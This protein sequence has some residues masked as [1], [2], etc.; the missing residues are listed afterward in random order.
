MFQELDT[1]VL[2]HDMDEYGL[3]QGDIGTEGVSHFKLTDRLA[4]TETLLTIACSYLRGVSPD[5]LFVLMERDGAKYKMFSS[6]RKREEQTPIFV[7]SRY[8]PD[9]FLDHFR[10]G[11]CKSNNVSCKRCSEI[12]RKTVSIAEWLKAANIPAD[13]EPFIPCKLRQR[14]RSVSQFTSQLTSR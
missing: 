14:F 4:T 8:L 5:N 6:S 1:V 10:N 3:K 9:D 11:D 2:T 7:A 13:L 12:E